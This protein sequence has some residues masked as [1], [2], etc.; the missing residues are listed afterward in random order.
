MFDGTHALNNLRMPLVVMLI[1]DGNGESQIVGLAV[2]R[3]ENA[4]SFQNFFTEFKA[5]NP[6]HDQI[7]V[8]M[9]DKSFANR[10]V[11]MLLSQ[12]RNINC[13]FFMLTK[14]LN[15]KSQQKNGIYL[16]S[17]EQKQ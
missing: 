5:D 9:S 17:N 3:S 6:K 7:K 14:Y 1:V 8:I 2:V 11:L 16:L 4:D 10:N 13:V 15:V 12:T